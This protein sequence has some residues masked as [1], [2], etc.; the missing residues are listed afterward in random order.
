MREKIVRRGR[1]FAIDRVEQERTQREKVREKGEENER[2]S[3]GWR[4]RGND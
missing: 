1:Y 3:V 2:L 4:E